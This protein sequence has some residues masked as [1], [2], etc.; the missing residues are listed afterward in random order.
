MELLREACIRSSVRLGGRQ[1]VAVRP[2]Q[3]LPET[4]QPGAI[5]PRNGPSLL[6][7]TSVSNAILHQSY[8]P[9]TEAVILRR[10]NCMRRSSDASSKTSS[11][12]VRFPF[13]HKSETAT[14]TQP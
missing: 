7:F 8:E 13:W 6:I 10:G 11:A 1:T 4:G 12:G 2:R 14:K 5:H 3:A 9:L